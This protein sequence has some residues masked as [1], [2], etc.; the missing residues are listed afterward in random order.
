MNGLGVEDVFSHWFGAEKVYG[1]MAFI[2]ANRMRPVN[3]D[4][5]LQVKHI[6]HGALHIGHALDRQE[7]LRLV[8]AL[9]R[10]SELEQMITIAD[11]YL[12]ARYS[13]I[14]Y[15][16]LSFRRINLLCEF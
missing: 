4:E 2:C 1:G 9:W 8:K 16:S 15:I 7:D 5:A 13:K 14:Y 12:V 10:G 6:A 3:E 11:S